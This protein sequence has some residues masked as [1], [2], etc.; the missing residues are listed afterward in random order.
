MGIFFVKFY[1]KHQTQKYL[2][3]KYDRN[4]LIPSYTDTPAPT[5][6]A[7]PTVMPLKKSWA[8]KFL[9]VVVVLKGTLVFSFWPKQHIYNCE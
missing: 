1:Q 8:L 3:Q 2:S 9:G 6:K 7:A 4:H 5:C